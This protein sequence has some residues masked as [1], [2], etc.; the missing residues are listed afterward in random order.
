MILN[1]EF[2]SV[3]LPTVILPIAVWP[4]VAA[5]R[6]IIG[7][8]VTVLVLNMIKSI[9]VAVADTIGKQVKTDENL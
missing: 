6:R 1:I 5:P 8:C 9:F 2:F 3:S 7:T 4:T